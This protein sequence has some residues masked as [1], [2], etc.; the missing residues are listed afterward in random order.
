MKS[1]KHDKD[2]SQ[3]LFQSLQ[4]A[5]SSYGITTEFHYRIFEE[6][7]VKPAAIPTYIEN[8]EDL[9]NVERATMGGKFHI[10]LA[11]FTDFRKLVL[12]FKNTKRNQ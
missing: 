3:D 10:H 12:V 7:E 1:V 8:Q 4:I 9:I 5:G 11:T 2:S 6:P